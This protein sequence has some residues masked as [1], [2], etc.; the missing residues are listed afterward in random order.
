[1][2]EVESE[3]M[4]TTS[5]SATVRERSYFG[6]LMFRVGSV[7]WLLAIGGLAGI[8]YQ[9]QFKNEPSSRDAA[10]ATGQPSESVGDSPKSLV[11]KTNRDGGIEFVDGAKA[12]TEAKWDK[13]GIAD[14]EFL[15]TDGQQ[16]TKADLLGKPWVVCFVFT[17]CAATCP[18]VTNSMRELQDRL[19]DCDFRLVT[20]TV[21]PERDTPEILKGYGESRGADFSKWMF[22]GGEQRAIYKL[23]HGSFKMPVKEMVGQDRQPGFEFIH[24]NNIMLVDAAGVVHGKFDATKGEAMSALRREIQKLAKGVADNETDSR[25]KP[26]A[27][28]GTKPNESVPPRADE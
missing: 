28:D 27:D 5:Q 17:H 2:L 26:A 8:W 9:R 4:E 14:F 21:D 18:M 1:M 11:I 13:E 12:V 16:V 10:T 20:L 3:I 23:I 19:Q 24:S 15:N 7:L 25:T 6:S 22:L